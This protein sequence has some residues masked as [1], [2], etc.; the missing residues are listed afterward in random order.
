M[1][2][3]LAGTLNE[4]HILGHGSGSAQPGQ[5]KPSND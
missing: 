1:S 4:Y 5:F 2:H 3:A